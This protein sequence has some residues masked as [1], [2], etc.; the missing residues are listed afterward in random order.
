MIEGQHFFALNGDT[1]L[2]LD[3]PAFEEL[4][5]TRQALLGMALAHVPD[6]AR[7]GAVMVSAQCVDRFVEK[8]RVGP[9]YINAGVYCI[10]KSIFADRPRGENF[11]FEKEILEPQVA[12]GGVVAY[13]VTSGFI[14]IGVPEDY[15]RAQN[16]IKA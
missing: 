4:L 13:T 15:K 12:R 8:G 16:E 2:Q 14:D 7:Y 3:Y 5:S 6:T 1:F 11:S 10:D 9:G